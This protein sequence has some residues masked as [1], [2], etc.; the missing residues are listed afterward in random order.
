MDI[1]RILVKDIVASV[2]ARRALWFKSWGADSFSKSS[3]WGLPFLG[4]LFFGEDTHVS[5][6]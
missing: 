1:V 5:R 2:V 3:L 4:S 6:S